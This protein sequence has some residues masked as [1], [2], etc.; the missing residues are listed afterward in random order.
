MQRLSGKTALVT[1]STRGLGRTTV[2]WLANEGANVVVNGRDA[3]DVTEVVKAMEGLGVKAY[4]IAADLSIVDEAHRL[5]NETFAAVGELDILVN[6][7]GMSYQEPFWGITDERWEYQTNVNYRSPFILCQHFAKHLMG[8][9]ARG[10]IV[11]F[12][13]IGAHGCHA[14]RAVYDAAKG[15][16][17]TMTRNM[18]FEL[19]PYGINVNC[20]IPGAIA[21][22]PGADG[23]TP[24]WDR[25][26]RN[27]IPIG[28]VGR[29]EDI[30]VTV[31]FFCLPE[32]EFITGQGLLVDGGHHDWL[33]ESTE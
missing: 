7:A 26:A 30:A 17:E 22:R 2:E 15:A 31:L 33:P 23:H 24:E 9:K 4:G 10:R 3:D 28:R 1:G 11:N 12:S 13:T 18:S 8:R 25:Y 19:G 29:A 5:A 20:V 32:T 6:N 21:E 16:V 27:N 14:D